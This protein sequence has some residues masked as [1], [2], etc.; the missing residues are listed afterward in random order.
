M[1]EFI[2]K[3]KL[4]FGN[5]GELWSTME[6]SGVC[7][8]LFLFADEGWILGKDLASDISLCA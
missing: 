8:V 7:Q 2:S 4:N 3:K 5:S 6:Y 1:T